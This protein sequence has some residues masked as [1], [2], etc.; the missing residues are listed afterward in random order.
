MQRKKVPES[1]CDPTLQRY[2]FLSD[3][4]SVH[5]H[6]C[7]YINDILYPMFLTNLSGISIR[8]LNPLHM[9]HDVLAGP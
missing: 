6:R 2:C 4:F 8:A 5:I 1:N 9:E 7:T 3:F